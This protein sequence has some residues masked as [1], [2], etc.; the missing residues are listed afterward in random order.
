MR[1]GTQRTGEYVTG[2]PGVPLANVQE[3][4]G[5]H[6]LSPTRTSELKLSIAACQALEGRGS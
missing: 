5:P 2:V 4:D 3:T 1:G 6:P